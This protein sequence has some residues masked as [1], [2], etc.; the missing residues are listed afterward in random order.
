MNK[1]LLLLIAT[2]TI[3]TT[4]AQQKKKEEKEEKYPKGYARVGAGY[5]TA[6]GGAVQGGLFSLNNTD[7][8]PL[9]GSINI[10]A[11][12]GTRTYDMKR[13]S[14]S[15]GVHGILALGINFNKNIGAEVVANVGLLTNQITSRI[16]SIQTQTNHYI[17]VTQRTDNPVFI[18]PSLVV[19]TGG[20]INIYARGGICLPAVSNI[21]QTLNYTAET[22]NPADSTFVTESISLSENYKMKFAAG[23][24]GAMGVQINAGKNLKLWAEAGI[25]SMTLYYNKS[26]LTAYSENGQSFFNQIPE[27]SKTTTYN[28]KGTTD[29]TNNQAPTTQ[30]QFSNFNISVGITVPIY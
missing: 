7:L 24:S 12:R 10:S 11:V 6:Y 5:A 9:N 21:S 13:T 15:A 17:D 26:V 23:F 30:V 19:Q 28:F 1:I 3:T 29:G 27:S 16:E 8:I 18:T 25:M 2:L 4:Y 14:F 22:Y 20:K